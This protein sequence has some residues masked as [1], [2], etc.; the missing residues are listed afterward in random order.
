MTGDE[1]GENLNVKTPMK[2][3]KDGISGLHTMSRQRQRA[4]QRPTAQ[5]IPSGR[6]MTIQNRPREATDLPAADQ[7]GH[8]EGRKAV[9]D[10][11]KN[12]T[13]LPA[14]DQTG[15]S[16][17]MGN[18]GDQPNPVTGSRIRMMSGVQRKQRV[19]PKHRSEVKA[20]RFVSRYL[21]KGGVTGNGNLSAAGIPVRR[22][23]IKPYASHI[24]VQTGTNHTRSVKKRQWDPEFLPGKLF[25]CGKKSSSG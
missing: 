13:D 11:E 14:A 23:G 3:E 1:K 19:R 7:T 6:R 9:K 5:V 17:R 20:D 18:A 25:L 10:Q 16:V 8:S 2:I 15:R 22:K 4:D 12:V 24:A 21:K